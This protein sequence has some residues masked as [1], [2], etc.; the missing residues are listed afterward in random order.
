MRHSIK[1]ELKSNT[2][3]FQVISIKTKM[4]FDLQSELFM[5]ETNILT[6]KVGA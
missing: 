3:S 2:A 4:K 5:V 6:G 1:T